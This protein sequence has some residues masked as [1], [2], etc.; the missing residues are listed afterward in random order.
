MEIKKIERVLN[1]ILHMFMTK[2]DQ[3]PPT[4]SSMLLQEPTRLLQV[5][6]QPTPRIPMTTTYI[7]I[8]TWIR[9]SASCNGVWVGNGRVA[10]GDGVRRITVGPTIRGDDGGGRVAM[11]SMICERVAMCG[12]GGWIAKGDGVVGWA[13]ATMGRVS[14]MGV[15]VFAKI[16]LGLAKLLSKAL[17]LAE[18]RGSAEEVGSLASQ[19][20]LVRLGAARG[21]RWLLVTPSMRRVVV[22]V[23][24]CLDPTEWEL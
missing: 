16:I 19:I 5:V 24:S 17:P 21:W 15:L 12:L 11:G 20:G 14:G 22:W 8:S 9:V 7:P 10:K 4:F 6:T 1:Q 3:C 23:H 13:W 18:T 2:Y